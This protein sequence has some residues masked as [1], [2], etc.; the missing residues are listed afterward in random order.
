MEKK[1]LIRIGIG[2]EE[3]THGQFSHRR[4]TATSNKGSFNIAVS[5]AE[6]EFLGRLQKL[7]KLNCE[8][9]DLL[10]VQ[11]LEEPSYPTEYR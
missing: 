4:A 10:V 6:R 2:C 9:T 1:K 7:I 3:A 8:G 5:L 11:D